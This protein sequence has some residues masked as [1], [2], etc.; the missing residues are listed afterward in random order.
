MQRSDV[1]SALPSPTCDRRM[2]WCAEDD[3]D[4]VADAREALAKNLSLR[5]IAS[6]HHVRAAGRPG[7]RQQ[8]AT[9]GPVGIEPTT[10]GLKVRCSAN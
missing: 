4:V 7:V 1:T 3:A 8:I 5:V 9:V 10:R 2:W 6:A